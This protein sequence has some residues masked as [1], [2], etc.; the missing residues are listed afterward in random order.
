M[1][2][3]RLQLIRVTATSW[4]QLFRQSV[5][6][7]MLVVDG[8]ESPISERLGRIGNLQVENTSRCQERPDAFECRHERGEVRQY[9]QSDN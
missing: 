4:R 9:V 3:L 2:S 5:V 1:P 8:V 7:Y 6:A